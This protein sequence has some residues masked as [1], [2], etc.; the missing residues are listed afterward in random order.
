MHQSDGRLTKRGENKEPPRYQVQQSESEADIDEMLADLV[1]IIISGI[2]ALPAERTDTPVTTEKTQ[3][4]RDSFHAGLPL[5]KH[6][7]SGGETI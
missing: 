5:A 2:G 1:D 7:S 6:P 4:E 3:G